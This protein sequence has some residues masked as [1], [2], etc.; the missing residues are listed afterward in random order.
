MSS[1]FLNLFWVC[2]LFFIII[3]LSYHDYKY[4]G[5]EKQQEHFMHFYIH[6]FRHVK[7]NLPIFEVD[8]GQLDEARYE[9]NTTRGINGDKELKH[10]LLTQAEQI[11]M[12]KFPRAA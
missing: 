11:G 3:W 9:R 8:L 12:Q 7:V 6:M 2:Y 4:T 1:V 5:N 10:K